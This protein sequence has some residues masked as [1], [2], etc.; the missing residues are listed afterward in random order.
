LGLATA[1]GLLSLAVRRGG[2]LLLSWAYRV[3][4]RSPA[5]ELPTAASARRFPAPAAF[6]IAIT[7][8]GYEELVWRG[9]LQAGLAASFGA[10]AAVVAT[11]LAFAAL[12]ARQGPVAAVFSAVA[13][14]LLGA[15]FVWHGNLAAVMLAHAAY[16]ASAVAVD[17]WGPPAV[18]RAAARSAGAR[19]S[20]STQG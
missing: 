1:L 18:R 7:A 10:P 14:A 15:A 20:I 12:H 8:A 5:A 17:R 2:A 11:S 19:L 16:N 9:F 4:G 3:S 13:A 6:L